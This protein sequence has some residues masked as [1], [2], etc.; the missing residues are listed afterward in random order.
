MGRTRTRWL[1][2]ALVLLQGVTWASGDVFEWSADS[3]QAQYA[4]LHRSILNGTAPAGARRYLIWTCGKTFLTPGCNLKSKA[5]NCVG[6]ANRLMGI[7]SVF[8]A[9]LVTQRA[10]LVAWPGL[11]GELLHNFFRS[12]LLDWRLN[13]T[14]MEQLGITAGAN[15]DDISEY[16]ERAPGD[17][18]TH[19]ILSLFNGEMGDVVLVASERAD[20]RDIFRCVCGIDNC[21]LQNH[22]P[23][24]PTFRIYQ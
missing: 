24:Q 23:I 4:E 2:L 12:D 15:S 9:A 3:W 22:R 5:C 19:D 6:Y 1:V 17:W 8:L 20:F 11:E 14:L 21:S 18:A 16:L 13:E 7:A 10:F